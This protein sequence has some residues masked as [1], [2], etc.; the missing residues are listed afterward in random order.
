MIGVRKRQGTGRSFGDGATH[1]YEVCQLRGGGKI[2][3][4][5]TYSRL[6]RERDHRCSVTLVVRLFA[7]YPETVVTVS[8]IVEP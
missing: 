4:I 7:T 8:R 5:V 2:T 1:A 6:I 3:T